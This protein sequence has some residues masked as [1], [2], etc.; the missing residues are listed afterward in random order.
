MLLHY[1]AAHSRPLEVLRVVLG[2]YPA[3]ANISDLHGLL[4]LSVAHLAGCGAE[5]CDCGWKR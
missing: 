2:A 3:A 5:A 4:P 1:A